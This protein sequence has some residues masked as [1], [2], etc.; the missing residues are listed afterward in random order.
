M[1][2]LLIVGLCNAR[3]LLLLLPLM[4]SLRCKD[5]K[6]KAVGPMERCKKDC[7]L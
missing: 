4:I 1:C 3:L 6:T 2:I 5:C 7:L